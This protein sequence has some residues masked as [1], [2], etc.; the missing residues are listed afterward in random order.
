MCCSI[1]GNKEPAQERTGSWSIISDL[2]KWGYAREAG[3][4][5]ASFATC[6]EKALEGGG[7]RRGHGDCGTGRQ[8]AR[9][10]RVL[11]YVR[12]RRSHFYFS[13]K[14][15]SLLAI[16]SKETRAGSLVIMSVVMVLVV[17]V[18]AGSSAVG[19]CS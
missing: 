11:R 3:K 1:F 5:G 7:G 12:T 10:G 18:M 8:C 4:I 9:Q 14:A 19:R 17:A 6:L 16:I 13:K 15:S 2:L